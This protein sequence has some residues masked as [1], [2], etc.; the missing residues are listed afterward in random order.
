MV[1]TLHSE[2]S[3]NSRGGST[4]LLGTNLLVGVYSPGAYEYTR[5]TPFWWIARHCSVPGEETGLVNYARVAEVVLLP[6]LKSRICGFN[7]CSLHQVI[8]LR[9]GKWFK[10]PCLERGRSRFE[11]WGGDKGSDEGTL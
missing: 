2:C 5:A 9:L 3:V 10:P 6:G 1:A 4:P 7:S 8:Y 11:S